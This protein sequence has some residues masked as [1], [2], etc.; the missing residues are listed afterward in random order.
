CTLY[1]ILDPDVILIGGGISAEPA[2][3]EGIMRYVNEIKQTDPILN[4]IRLDV[5]K[6]RN[7]SNLF[8]ALYNFKQ[9]YKEA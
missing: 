5:C 8:G 7:D 6:Y 2:F 1:A 9:K 3:F 4:E